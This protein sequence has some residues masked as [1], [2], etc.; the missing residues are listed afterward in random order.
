MG[1]SCCGVGSVPGANRHPFL[2]PSRPPPAPGA[3][4]PKPLLRLSPH[5]LA[6]EAGSGGAVPAAPGGHGAGEGET[7]REGGQ[8]G[9][10]AGTQTAQRW[11]RAGTD[12]GRAATMH[13]DKRGHR[14]MAAGMGQP[15]VAPAVQTDPRGRGCAHRQAPH[16]APHAP[17]HR[18]SCLSRDTVIN[19]QTD[20]Q[21]QRCRDTHTHTHGHITV[22]STPP[23]RPPASRRA[24]RAK[25]QRMPRDT[26]R[27]AKHTQTRA[28]GDAAGGPGGG[29][30]GGTGRPPSRTP[31]HTRLARPGGT[32]PRE[33]RRA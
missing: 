7:R 31:T 10:A 28:D 5:T 19:R 14:H 2:L 9:A 8:P 16:A 22:G 29:G 6:G 3:P 18:G 33:D 30:D 15:W 11:R 25:P 4:Q 17:T 24:Q 1:A 12:R 21:A 32:A 26:H 27:H 13:G 20:R 23:A